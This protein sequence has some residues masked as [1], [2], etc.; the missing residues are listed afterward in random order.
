M[1]T[2]RC[3]ALFKKAMSSLELK[4]PPV[5]LIV[6]LGVTM[7]GAEQL[8][9]EFQIMVPGAYFLALG[10]ALG[11]AS[12]ALMGVVEFRK[13]QTTV[14]PRNPQKSANLV[15]AGIYRRSRNPMYLGFLLLLSAWA[16]Y[17]ANPLGFFALPFYV[18]YMNRFQIRPE[19]RFMLQKFGEQY[20]AYMAQVRRWI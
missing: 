16:V 13:A 10:F 2:F 3:L 6:L 19:E 20:Q 7:S 15:V 12:V 14:D 1:R 11:G 4:V 5:L 18:A 8:F 17:L 9:P